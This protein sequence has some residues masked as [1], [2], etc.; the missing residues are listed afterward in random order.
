MDPLDVDVLDDAIMPAVD[1]RL[2]GGLSFNELSEF[3]KII[4]ATRHSIGID[5]TIFNP[6][7]DSDGSIA[8]RFVSSILEGL[9]L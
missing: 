6:N 7:L 8:Y 2:K 1:Y 4:V 3:L 9:S 5:I